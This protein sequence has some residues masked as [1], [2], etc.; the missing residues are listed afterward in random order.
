MALSRGGRAYIVM[1]R[2]REDII[3]HGKGGRG[4]ATSVSEEQCLRDLINSYHQ[5]KKHWHSMAF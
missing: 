2:R 3:Y 1:G 5:Q 4:G